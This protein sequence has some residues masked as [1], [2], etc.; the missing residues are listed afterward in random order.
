V[1]IAIIGVL[2]GLLLPAVQAAREAARRMQ[3]T[4]NLKQLG[5]ATHNFHDVKQRLPCG[6]NDPDWTAYKKPDVTPIVQVD[7]VQQYSPFVTLS[8]FIEQQA[9][10]NTLTS[11]LSKATSTSPYDD[12]LVP[13][14]Q[15]RLNAGASPPINTTVV[16]GQPNP[17]RTEFSTLLCPSDGST[18]LPASPAANVTGATNYRG[19]R[20][21]AQVASSSNVTRGLFPLGSNSTFSF[22]NV[23]DGT[24]NTILF[25]ESAV[26]SRSAGA[27]DK[28]I[29]SGIALITTA[30]TASIP[31]DCA[32]TR[33]TSGLFKDIYT[34]YGG[35]G[36]LWGDSRTLY[37]VFQTI[38]PPNS[39]TCVFDTTAPARNLIISASSYH[40][41]GVNV[42]LLD[43]SVR[44]VPDT[45]DAE[46]TVTITAAEAINPTG[47]SKYGVWGAL[48]TSTG[49]E[50][51]QL[52]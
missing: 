15:S 26:I 44:F 30:I 13:D 8:P 45:I 21:D 20:G 2:V 51:S 22:S 36:T 38:L 10:H 4:N 3:C 1:V 12:T 24:S 27:N 17:F 40:T 5:I 43:G 28:R 6:E 29:I 52:P 18:K 32:A 19:N 37:T 14:P 23:T 42:G 46:P 49:Q 11:M 34:T 41:G 35:K 25:S 33:G 9:F 39:P 48:G 16:D 7:Y 50:T 31:S 47:P